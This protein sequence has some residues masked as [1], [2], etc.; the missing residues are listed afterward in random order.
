MC[1]IAV[2]RDV[3]LVYLDLRRAQGPRRGGDQFTPVAAPRQQQGY[4]P[5]R[6]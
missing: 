4:A 5:L 2:T 1:D 6:A 3:G